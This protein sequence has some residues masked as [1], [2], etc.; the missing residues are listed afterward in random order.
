MLSRHSTA[1]RDAATPAASTVAPQS[2]PADDFPI[3]ESAMKGICARSLY[4][5]ATSIRFMAQVTASVYKVG[6]ACVVLP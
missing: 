2:V 6:I 1:A 5:I 3:F 4:E